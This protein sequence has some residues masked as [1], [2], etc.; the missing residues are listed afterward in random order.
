MKKIKKELENLCGDLS[1]VK[2]LLCVMGRAADEQAS[3]MD[4]DILKACHEEMSFALDFIADA[5]G[6]KM[7]ALFSLIEEMPEDEVCDVA[8]S[9]EEKKVIEIYRNLDNV[10]T[11]ESLLRGFRNGYN[12]K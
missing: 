8:I 2:H 10:E 1:K 9:E 4:V 5:I 11:L 12:Y 3:W 7:N 6:I